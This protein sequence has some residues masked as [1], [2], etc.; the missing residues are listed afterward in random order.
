MEII[1][2][3]FPQNSNN[4]D[5]N[6]KEIVDRINSL[7]QEFKAV[8]TQADKEQTF[9]YFTRTV[10]ILT[11]MENPEKIFIGE[12]NLDEFIYDCILEAKSMRAII[13]NPQTA[14][15]SQNSQD[16]NLDLDFIME[17]IQH[18]IP[19]KINL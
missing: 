12:V 14:N 1:D 15:S 18:D 4:Q 9:R 13:T 16:A 8:E 17:M 19:P 2:K 3:P 7:K 6:I 11:E 10:N 5:Q